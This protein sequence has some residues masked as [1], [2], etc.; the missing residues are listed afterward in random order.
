LI[1]KVNTP[2]LSVE[3]PALALEGYTAISGREGEWLSGS[4]GTDKTRDPGPY[5]PDTGHAHTT[6]SAS[7]DS[8]LARVEMEE[9]KDAIS[10]GCRTG[11]R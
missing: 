7:I 1:E 9:A 8:L 4:M 11:I 5:C 10:V 2:S 6:C 3:S